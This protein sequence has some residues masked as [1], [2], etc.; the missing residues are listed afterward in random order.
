M[1]EFDEGLVSRLCDEFYDKGHMSPH[2]VARAILPK[3]RAAKR[4]PPTPRPN[5][6]DLIARVQA[7][8]QGS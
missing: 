2:E 6:M 5:A 8:M 4:P 1:D 7:V 3:M